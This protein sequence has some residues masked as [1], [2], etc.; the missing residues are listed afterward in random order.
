MKRMWAVLLHLTSGSSQTEFAFDESLWNDILKKMKEGGLNTIILGVKGGVRWGSHPEIA[1]KGAWSRQRLCD[2]VKRLKDMGFEVVPKLNF[3]TSHRE[4]LGAYARMVSTPIYYRVCRELIEETYEIFDHPRYIH[5]G[6][7]EEDAEH[8]RYRSDLTVLRF[9]DL[10]F[11]DLEYLCDCVRATGAM[12]WM[13]PCSF[14]WYPDEFKK[15]FAPGSVVLS[16]AMYNAF[17]K[18]HYTPITSREVYMAYYSSEKYKNLHIEFVEDDPFVVRYHQHNLPGIEYGY[19]YVPCASLCNR[20]EYN[21]VEMVEHYKLNAPQ[22]ERLIGF[23]TAPWKPTI[24]EFRDIHI[25]SLDSLIE[26]KNMFYPNE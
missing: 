5:L 7:D 3:S 21:H 11:H 12:P 10:L 9:G 19:S 17:R 22:D 23:M 26:A 20:C 2:E 14:F 4:W 16:P 25:Q 24:E 8:L 6:M 15:H 1:I 18:E 13:W